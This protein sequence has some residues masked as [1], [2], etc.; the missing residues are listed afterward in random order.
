MESFGT[1]LKYLRKQDGRTLKDFSKLFGLSISY[2][3]QLE[4][5]KN[6]PSEQTILNI[7]R[8]LGVNREWLE[9]G[10]G[11]AR[12]EVQLYRKEDTWDPQRDALNRAIEADPDFQEIL[13]KGLCG[14]RTQRRRFKK[15]MELLA[16]WL[17][18][19]PPT[20][21]IKREI[22]RKEIERD[23]MADMA[24]MKDEDEKSSS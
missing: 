7:C 9:N 8:A 4:K 21:G 20:S 18:S 2:I 11:N 22:N 23:I 14:T 5:D 3:S 15:F 6:T 12:I 16:D 24:E 1:R 17:P 10:K 13:Y 19:R